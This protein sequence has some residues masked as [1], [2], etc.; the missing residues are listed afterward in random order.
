MLTA[1]QIL[2]SKSHQTIHAVTPDTSVLDAVRT[3]T[4]KRIGA[5]LVMQDGSVLGIVTERDLARKFAPMNRLPSETPVRDIMTAPIV[6]V[7]PSES[8]ETCLALMAERQ[9]RHLPVIDNGKLTGLISITDLI[10]E[11]PAQQQFI[12]DQLNRYIRGDFR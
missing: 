2:Q 7:G 12:I 3:M 9:F 8:A 5:L 10:R 1:G 6:H 11:V 4:D